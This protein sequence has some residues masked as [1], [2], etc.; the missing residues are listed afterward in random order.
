MNHEN[1][2]ENLEFV[3]YYNQGDV[4]FKDNLLGTNR[5]GHVL[6]RKDEVV[7][8]LSTLKIEILESLPFYQNIL[9]NVMIVKPNK[10][11]LDSMMKIENKS[12]KN[13]SENASREM[14]KQRLDQ[15]CLFL[16][17]IEIATGKEVGFYTGVPLK[18]DLSCD[19]NNWYFYN[20]VSTNS[21]IR[22]E[23][24][25]KY[26]FDHLDFLKGVIGKS[27]PN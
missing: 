12:W 3:T 10:D 19:N 1:I 25:Y 14:L 22:K 23:N 6:G 9:S 15:N 16:L 5:L 17:A 21:S 18:E 4:I 11:Y 26:H 7:D 24:A 20:E 27:F 8:F 2:S 13:H